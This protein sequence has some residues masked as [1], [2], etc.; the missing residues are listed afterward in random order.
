V[1]RVRAASAPAAEAARRPDPLVALV[2]AVQAIPEDAWARGTAAAEVV[3]PDV[4]IAPIAIA[5]LETPALAD[6]PAEPIAPGER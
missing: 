4:T 3:A 6:A 5:P 2:R 1:D